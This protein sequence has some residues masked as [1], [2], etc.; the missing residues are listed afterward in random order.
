MF[1]RIDQ[2]VGDLGRVVG[3]SI[4][5]LARRGIVATLEEAVDF[6]RLLELLHDVPRLARQAVN[7]FRGQIETGVM[8]RR[9]VIDRDQQPDERERVDRGVGAVTRGAAGRYRRESGAARGDPENDRKQ[10]ADQI[11]PY[12]QAKSGRDKIIDQPE[13]EQDQAEYS[14]K[15]R[16]SPH[17]P[18]SFTASA[19]TR[20]N[21]GSR[22]APR[23]S[24]SGNKRGREYR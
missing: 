23:K 20:P 7:F 24:D 1:V 17:P 15:R 19:R 4:V 6:E 2:F 5:E 11:A 3:E 12:E 16:R 14:V 18:L 22:T 10:A 13:G 9:D 21:V 8:Q